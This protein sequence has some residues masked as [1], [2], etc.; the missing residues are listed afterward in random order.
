MALWQQKFRSVPAALAEVIESTEDPKQ[1][2]DW[3]DRVLAAR[4]LEDLRAEEQG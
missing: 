4:R 1:F 2:E 3:L